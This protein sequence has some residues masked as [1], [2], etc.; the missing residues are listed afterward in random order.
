M[1]EWIVEG[2]LIQAD[3]DGHRRDWCL[4]EE[5]EVIDSRKRLTGSY[6]NTCDIFNR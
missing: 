3:E 6:H 4:Y 1:L 2:G 5:R